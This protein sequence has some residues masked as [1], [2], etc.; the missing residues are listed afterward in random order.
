MSSYRVRFIN[1][2]YNT[3]KSVV[4]QQRAVTTGTVYPNGTAWIIKFL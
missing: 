2:N 3:G 4:D 1:E